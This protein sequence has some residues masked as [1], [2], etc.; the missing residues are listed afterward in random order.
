MTDLPE[1]GATDIWAAANWTGVNADDGRRTPKPHPGWEAPT[2]GTC[3]Q[4]NKYRG[5]NLGVLRKLRMVP[6]QIHLNHE[7]LPQYP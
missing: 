5:A 7:Q 1:L 3:C 2:T 6:P 4:S